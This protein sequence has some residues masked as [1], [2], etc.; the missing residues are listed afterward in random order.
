MYEIAP[1]IHNVYIY[2]RLTTHFVLNLLKTVHVLEMVLYF[3]TL[4][5]ISFF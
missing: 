5:E 2:I 4:F 1:C 3:L